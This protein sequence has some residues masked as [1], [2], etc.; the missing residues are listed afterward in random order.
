MGPGPGPGGFGPAVPDAER[1]PSVAGDID[2][3]GIG[4]A[5]DNCP[6]VANA[7]QRE[8]ACLYPDRPELLDDVV[9][10]AVSRVNWHRLRS[11]L[12][13]VEHDPDLTAGCELHVQYLVDC[14]MGLEHPE[15][16]CPELGTPEGAQAGIDSVLSL[17]RGDMASAVDGWM[18]TLYHRLPLIHPGLQRIGAAMLEGHACIQY[19]RG[20]DYSV[21]ANFPVLYPPPDVQ[22]TSRAFQ[23]NESPCPTTEDPFGAGGC[24]PSGAIS[25][26]GLYGMGAISNV[27]ATLTN[28]AT[29]EP[30]ELFKVY[31][32][33]GPTPHEQQGYLDESVALIPL[34]NTELERAP[35]EVHVS[36]ALDGEV[37]EFRWRFTTGQPLPDLNCD[38]D[39]DHGRIDRAITLSRGGTNTGSI[40]IFP[41]WYFI[42]GE[43]M[44]TV[45]IEFRHDAGDLDLVATNNVGDVIERA[46]GP[47]DVET[48]M[49]PG[50]NYV[51]VYGQNNGMAP[52]SIFVE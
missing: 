16:R 27:S 51:Q 18:N 11:G 46:E 49:L 24:P 31:W 37:Q 29:G 12:A 36:A 40:C 41:D 10:D 6:S 13:P 5:A 17:G 8:I 42:E 22:T 45:R 44:H 52:Y 50:N 21:G 25:T 34:P 23:G 26:M 3:D 28:L 7:D 39:G 30:V 2:G 35:Y 47:N 15:N 20:T 19:R 4:D 43:G 48:V 14:G 33:G 1:G 9:G 38:D 32:E